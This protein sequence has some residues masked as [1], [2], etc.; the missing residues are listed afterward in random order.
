MNILSVRAH[1]L[2]AG[3]LLASINAAPAFAQSAKPD[4]DGQHGDHDIIDKEIVVSGLLVRNR[5][6][7][8]PSGAHKAG[9]P[10]CKDV[11]K[12]TA[13]RR[14]GAR[15]R[16]GVPAKQTA[17]ILARID[18]SKGE[19]GTEAALSQSNSEIG[20]SRQPRGRRAGKQGEVL[21]MDG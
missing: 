5:L 4:V 6:D 2:L 15:G 17:E 16:R 13:C 7:V 14:E 1:L 9:T 20:R 21:P 3:S 18:I 19:G 8:L 11:S 10:T 12:G